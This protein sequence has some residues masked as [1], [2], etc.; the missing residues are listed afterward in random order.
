MRIFSSLTVCYGIG[1]RFFPT[2]WEPCLKEL[3]DEDTLPKRCS[4]QSYNLANPI[5]ICSKKKRKDLRAIQ[6]LNTFLDEVTFPSQRFL[7]LF[8]DIRWLFP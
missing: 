6:A 5:K 3:L 4:K 8:K 2:T 7:T 1:M